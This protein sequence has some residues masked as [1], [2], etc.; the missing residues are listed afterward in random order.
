ML[1]LNQK[2]KDDSKISFSQQRVMEGWCQSH[3]CQFIIIII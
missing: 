3:T 1:T 2:E